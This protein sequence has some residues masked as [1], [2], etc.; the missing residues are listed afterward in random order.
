MKERLNILMAIIAMFFL[1]Q[2]AWG[3]TSYGITVAGI[4]V[5]SENAS[6]I[7]GDNINGTVK[8]ENSTRTLTLDNAT[9]N[10]CIYSFGDLTIDLKGENTITATDTCVIKSTITSMSPN[11]TFKTT[12]GTGNLWL[13]PWTYYVC[14]G[15]SEPSFENGLHVVFGDLQGGKGTTLITTQLFSGGNGTANS[16]YQ[17]GNAEDLRNLAVYMYSGLLSN[18]AFQLSADIDCDGLNGFI[19][20]GYKDDITDNS[21][22]GTFDGNSKTISNLSM[23]LTNNNRTYE[24]AGLFGYVSGGTIENL[25]LDNFL[26]KTEGAYA[27][28]IAGYVNGGT[29]KNN[30][31][32]GYSSVESANYTGAIIGD[33]SDATLEHNYYNI[34]VTTESTTEGWRYSYV[35]R[36]VGKGER[37]ASD[38][39]VSENDGAT[40]YKRTISFNGIKQSINDYVS[41]ALDAEIVQLQAQYDSNYIG[42]AMLYTV[43]VGVEVT[44]YYVTRCPPYDIQLVSI[45]NSATNETIPLTLKGTGDDYMAYSF[46]MPDADVRVDLNIREIEEYDLWIY[47]TQVTSDN[48]ANITDGVEEGTVSFAITNDPTTNEE[49]YTLTLNNATISQYQSVDAILFKYPKLTVQLVGENHIENGFV[50]TGTDAETGTVEFTSDGGEENCLIFNNATKPED[51]VYDNNSIYTTGFYRCTYNTIS[52]ETGWTIGYTDQGQ[53]KLYRNIITD[54]GL[55]VGGIAVTSANAS[56][57]LGDGN[58]DQNKAASFQYIPKLNKLFITNNTDGLKIE[59]TNDEGLTVYLAANSTNTVGSIVYTGNGN[60]PLTITT[61]GNYPGKI[62]MTA[63]ANVISGFSSLTLEQNLIVMDPEG[64]AYDGNN[65]RL[66]TKSATIGTPLNPITENKTIKPDG[67][68]LKPEAGSDDV[69]KVVDDILYTLGNANNSNGDGYDDSDGSIVL[70]TVTTDRQVAEVTQNCTPGTDEYLEGFKGLT[71]MVPAGKGEIV[72]DVQTQEGY[73]MKVVVGDSAPYIV[74]KTE[75][76]EVTM[77][78][79]VAEPTFVYA[80]NGGKADDANSTRGIQ[81]GKKTTVHIKVYSIKITSKKKQSNSA[82]QASD[83]EYKGDT[84]E[85]EGQEME[86]EADIEASRGDV[87]GDEAVNAADIV[88][89]VNAIMGKHSTLFDA[90]AADV[91]GDGTVNAADIVGIVNKIM[92]L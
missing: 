46:T 38:W 70:N 27:G 35:R 28:A 66:G 2:M 43:G 87:N 4:R 22:K 90:R 32:T 8:Y 78:Y 71:F 47:G 49:I 89:I 14:E 13:K 88:E 10:G 63:D 84:S 7:T 72:F 44:F 18:E 55:S 82:A 62:A 76:G 61:D 92:G 17:I 30:F 33:Y 1:P 85:L 68:E 48:A 40:L 73:A 59:T 86:S 56:D 67:N 52:D 83:G 58:A 64:M 37:D 19:P 5:T 36:G 54:Y 12:D 31:V 45:I 41:N 26:V 51:L 75:K 42:D 77:K 81:K 9:I 69:N 53:V 23:D 60:A 74:E 29:L 79:N 39:D 91:N 80:Y 3:Q 57:I 34:S 25:T 50:Y 6:A 65:K 21:F 24:Y 15:F 20:I 11:L 16:P